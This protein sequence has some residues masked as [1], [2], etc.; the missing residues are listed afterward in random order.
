M[1]PLGFA[2]M[3]PSSIILTIIQRPLWKRFTFQ[4]KWKAI[5]IIIT[6]FKMTFHG[7]KTI[8]RRRKSAQYSTKLHQFKWSVQNEQIQ[9]KQCQNTFLFIRQIVLKQ[10]NKS[11]SERNGAHSISNEAHLYIYTYILRRKD[12]VQYDRHESLLAI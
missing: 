8:Q 9:G 12:P 4:L 6:S 11:R 2:F 3:C 10:Q 1:I 5:I 7:L